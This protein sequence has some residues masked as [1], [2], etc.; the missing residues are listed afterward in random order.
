MDKKDV[1]PAVEERR[2]RWHY[3]GMVVLLL[4]DL[5]SHHTEKFLSDPQDRGIDVIF[6]VPYSSPHHNIQAFMDSGLV[7]VERKGDFS[8]SV[9]SENARRVRGH[10]PETGGIPPA[11]LAPEAMARIHLPNGREGPQ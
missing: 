5:G 9:Q 2:K 3:D 10:P 8:L 7:P 4:D 11:P 6:L 1:I